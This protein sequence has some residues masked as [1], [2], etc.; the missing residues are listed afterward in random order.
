MGDGYFDC[1]RR[2]D[3]KLMR[4]RVPPLLTEKAIKLRQIEMWSSISVT[5]YTSLL[6]GIRPPNGI[7]N[8]CDN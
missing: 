8:S 1:P 4:A 6:L 3:N 5:S 2:L 7:A